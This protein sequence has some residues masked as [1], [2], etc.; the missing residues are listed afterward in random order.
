MFL[1][2]SWRR[3]RGRTTNVSGK[4][5]DVFGKSTVTCGKAPREGKQ[6]KKREYFCKPPS[7]RPSAIR[8]WGR[9]DPEGR[10]YQFLGTRPLRRDT[11]EFVH[12]GDHAS[13]NYRNSY[14]FGRRDRQSLQIQMYPQAGAW[15]LKIGTVYPLGRKENKEAATESGPRPA[16]THRT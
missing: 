7:R 16:Q 2:R 1:E 15:Y 12:F 10:R 6:E 9:A 13:R 8:T 11:Y 5:Q 3:P 14:S 4:I